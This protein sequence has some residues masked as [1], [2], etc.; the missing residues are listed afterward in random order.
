MKTD[1]QTDRQ[2]EDQQSSMLLLRHFHIP[3]LDHLARSV[4]PTLLSE[5]M[6]IQDFQ[7]RKTFVHLLGETF[8][9]DQVWKQA[10]L[11]ICMGGFGLT[12]LSSIACSVF[13][14]SWSNTISELPSCF[15][16]LKV[17]MDIFTCDASSPVERAF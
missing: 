10:C 6:S 9:D 12:P 8:V 13:V 4:E 16:H 15:L 5:A 3:R 11:P 1:R 17:I 7:S 14:A 2:T